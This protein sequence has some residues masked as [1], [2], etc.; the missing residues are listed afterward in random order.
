MLHTGTPFNTGPYG[1][2][3]LIRA[4]A[5][6]GTEIR[7]VPDARHDGRRVGAV[8]A[9]LLGGTAFAYPPP[10]ARRWRW[11]RWSTGSGGGDDGSQ[12]R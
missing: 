6:P 1:Q 8:C 3:D 10:A 5:G 12:R 9:H 11:T 4:R 7:S 2:A